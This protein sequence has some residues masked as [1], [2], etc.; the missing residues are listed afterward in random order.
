MEDLEKLGE[1]LMTGKNADALRSLAASPEAKRLEA[2]LD[3]TETAAALRSGDSAAIS[4]L[5]KTVLATPEGRALAE[6]LSALEQR[7]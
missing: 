7:P 5:L 1:Q 3:G 6:K 4:R 2:A